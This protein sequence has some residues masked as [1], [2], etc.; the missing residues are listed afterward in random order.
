[1]TPGSTRLRRVTA[2]RR[3][4]DDW[5]EVLAPGLYRV[6]VAGGW[7]LVGRLSPRS[8]LRRALLVRLCLRTYGAFNRRD[9]PAFLGN[10]A[11]DCVYDTT[12]VAGWPEKQV[13]H[14]HSGLTEMANDWFA[15]WDFWLELEDVHD[16]GGNR[17]VVLADDRMTGTGSGVALESVLWTQVATVRRG[18]CVRVD[19]YT[20]RNEALEAVGLSE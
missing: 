10:F 9:L 4:V 12:H 11:P 13:Y 15:T 7:L 16:L 6:L 3:T 2:R 17:C 5:L 1:M 20:D 14:G 18:L 19:N 8:R